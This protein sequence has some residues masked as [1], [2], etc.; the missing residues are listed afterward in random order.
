[1]TVREAVFPQTRN[2][3]WN[4]DGSKAMTVREAVFPQTRNAIWNG[5]GSK[6]ITTNVFVNRIISITCTLNDRKVIA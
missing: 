6:A 4:G 2:A 1:M 5:D 3:I